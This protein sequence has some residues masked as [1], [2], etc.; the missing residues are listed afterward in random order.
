MSDTKQAIIELGDR[1]LREKGY[2]AFS[3]ADI[4]KQLDIK[5]AAIHYYFPSKSDLA[6]AIIDEHLQRLTEFTNAVAN[7]KPYDK[8]AQFLDTYTKA[9]EEGMICIVG[10]MATNWYSCDEA[11][12]QKVKEFTDSVTQWLTSTLQLGLN[13]GDFTFKESAYVK[14]L[15]IV[16]NMLAITQLKRIAGPRAFKDVKKAVLDSLTN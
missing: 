13:S 4:S 3:Y 1:L 15:L 10:T 12:Q 5:N 9:Q 8:I 14:A 6:A 2:N 16:T 11:M 7:K